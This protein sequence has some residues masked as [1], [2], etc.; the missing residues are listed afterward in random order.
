MVCIYFVLHEKYL[1]V[2]FVLLKRDYFEG[3]QGLKTGTQ[4]RELLK[5][6]RLLHVMMEKE[7]SSFPCSI[8]EKERNYSGCFLLPCRKTL[9]TLKWVWRQMYQ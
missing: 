1:N 8:S 5:Y 4:V 2:I 9:K 7:F 3:E 6:S